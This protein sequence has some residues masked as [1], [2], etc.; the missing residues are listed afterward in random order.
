M[1]ER[2]FNFK[3]KYFQTDYANDFSPLKPH[4]SQDGIIH[5]L[6]CNGLVERRHYE[7]EIGLTLLAQASV[8]WTF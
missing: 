5:C 2:L 7:A 8:P 6:S 3:I 4:F 1:V